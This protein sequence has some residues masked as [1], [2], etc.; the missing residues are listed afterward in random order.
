MRKQIN[1]FSEPKPLLS[2]IPKLLGLDGR[3]MSKSYNNTILL[4]DSN[5]ILNIKVKKMKTDSARVYIH[6]KGN[7]DK[8][9]VWGLHVIYTSLNKQIY[10][11]DMCVNGTGGCL[12]CKKVLIENLIKHHTPIRKIA[13]EYHKNIDFVDEILKT[14]ANNA[15]ENVLHSLKKVKEIINFSF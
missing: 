14:G 3:K 7:P 9:P 8:C 4:T 13:Q 2:S 1:I 10:L 6:D 12:E 15:R 11:K 5:D